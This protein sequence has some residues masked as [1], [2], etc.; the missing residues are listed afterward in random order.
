ML[1]EYTHCT[2]VI[3]C[4]LCQ[5]SDAGSPYPE[6]SGMQ[7]RDGMSS[8]YLFLVF[9]NACVVIQDGVL[10]ESATATD[11]LFKSQCGETSKAVSEVLAKLNQLTLI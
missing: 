8:Q 2:L 10:K 5:E 9:L 1:D 4:L 6:G 7:Y 3:A 11:L